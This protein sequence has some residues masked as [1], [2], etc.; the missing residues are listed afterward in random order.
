MYSSLILTDL[1]ADRRDNLIATADAHRAAT[2]ARTAR[3]TPAARVGRVSRWRRR[4]FRPE[5]PAS[6]SSA[7]MCTR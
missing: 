1:A 4:F 7:A 5:S 6:T 3:I 2:A